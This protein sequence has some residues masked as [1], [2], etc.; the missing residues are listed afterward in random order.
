MKKEIDSAA[1]QQGSVPNGSASL[2]E[3]NV[4]NIDFVETP[5]KE[6]M[7]TGYAATLCEHNYKGWIE[8]HFICGNCG[9]VLKTEI[10]K[11]NDVGYEFRNHTMITKYSR[12]V[13]YTKKKK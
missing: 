5:S 10:M 9:V 7:D 13:R 12:R 11:K 8:N 3:G 6:L 4:E 2:G 1:H